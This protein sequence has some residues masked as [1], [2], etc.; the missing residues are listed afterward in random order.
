MASPHASLIAAADAAGILPIITDDHPVVATQ[1]LRAGLGRTAWR[2]VS[3]PLEGGGVEHWYANPNG[4]LAYSRESDGRTRLVIF[5][6]RGTAV[7]D[8]RHVLRR[9][10]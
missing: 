5:D 2:E 3:G 4:A 10:A 6:Q 7:A 9:A 8:V 1:A